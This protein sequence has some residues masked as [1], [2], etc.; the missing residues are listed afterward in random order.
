MVIENIVLGSKSPRRKQL[1][2]SIFKKFSVFSKEV[3]ESFSDDMPSL[4]V[5]TYLSKKKFDETILDLGKNDFLIT[6][7]CVVIVGNE[8]L[9][10]PSDKAEALD[11][12]G[13]L[14]G[15]THLVK[16]GVTLGQRHEN[17]TVSDSTVV[18]FF[19]FSQSQMEYYIDT[20][21]PYDKAG[22]YGIQEWIGDVLIES[23][24]G[25][26]TTNSKTIQNPFRPFSSNFSIFSGEV[27]KL[28][29]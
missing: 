10:K 28:K 9:N 25:S 1:L 20:F 22:A 7:D 15:T 26:F 21:K 24:E 5:P 16:T 11:M 19:P 13:K 14:S 17:I 8:I 4:E 23:I 6:A 12:L 27:T 3:D 18:K 2:N 29:Y